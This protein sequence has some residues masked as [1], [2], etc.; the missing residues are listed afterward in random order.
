MKIVPLAAVPS[1]TL[2]IVLAN[3]L[4]TIEVRQ[5]F[6]GLFINLYVAGELVI[7]GVICRNLTKIV[8]SEYLGFD[9]DLAFIDG[10]GTSDPDYTGLGDRFSLA[11]LDADDLAAGAVT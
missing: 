11:Y 5:K 3:Q 8:R 1:Q 9:G 2:D 10:Q 4:C 6:F 7:G